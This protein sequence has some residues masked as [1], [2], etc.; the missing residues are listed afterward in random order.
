M[1]SCV[2]TPEKKQ[3]S[4]LHLHII[5]SQCELDIAG[6]RVDAC[7]TAIILPI[8]ILI[9]RQCIGVGARARSGYTGARWC[10]WQ[11]PDRAQRGTHGDW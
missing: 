1:A 9:I 7:I 6:G 3:I 10:A 5:H 8:V 11:R 2:L 4:P